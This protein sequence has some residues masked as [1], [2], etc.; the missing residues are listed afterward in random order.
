MA[1]TA[2]TGQASIGDGGS[3]A[4]RPKSKSFC[5]VTIKK[6]VHFVVVVAQ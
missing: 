4:K 2:A 6:S 5:V 1:K 3:L